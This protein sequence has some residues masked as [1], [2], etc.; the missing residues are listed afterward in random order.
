MANNLT[1]QYSNNFNVQVKTQEALPQF[2]KENMKSNLN[3]NHDP[4]KLQK[5]YEG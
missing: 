2:I 5:D 1:L 3:W 4:H